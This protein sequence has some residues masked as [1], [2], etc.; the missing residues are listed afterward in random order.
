AIL[1]MM[2]QMYLHSQ[3]D[4][5]RLGVMAEAGRTTGIFNDPTAGEGQFLRQFQDLF[6]NGL[7]TLTPVRIAQIVGQFHDVGKA[8]VYARQLERGS[9][10]RRLGGG[11]NEGVI[12]RTPWAP[13]TSGAGL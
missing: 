11:H 9:M 8:T 2:H 7:H 10:R 6:E 1:E 4:P 5:K 13:G 12:K 3:L